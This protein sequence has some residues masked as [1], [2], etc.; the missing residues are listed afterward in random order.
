LI[1]HQW[2]D[3]VTNFEDIAWPPLGPIYNLFQDE[4][5]V[6][7]EYIDEIFEKGLIW[8]SKSLVGTPILFVK[9]KDG[10]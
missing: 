3:Y 7:Q 5:M 2:Y 6:F 4:L 8:H 9:K 1:E 10:F